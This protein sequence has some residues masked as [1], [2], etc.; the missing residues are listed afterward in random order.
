MN[1]LDLSAIALPFG[2]YRSG[3]PFGITLFAP[4]LADLR[5]LSLGKTIE[6]SQPQQSVAIKTA[7]IDSGYQRIAVC[8]AHMQ[9]LPLNGQLQTLGGRF[10]GR[11]RTAPNYRMYLL[12]AMPPERPGLVRDTS[13]G[14]ALDL[15]LWDLPKANWADFI[16]NIKSP[17]CIG[18]VELENGDW[19][20]GF[21]CENYP[22]S[23]A[24]EITKFG[25]WRAYLFANR[26]I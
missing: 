18:S 12:T 23:N 11:M 21:L 17:L 2:F 20:Y 6:S 9:G 3:L 25:G 24:T 14:Q 15:E 22:L 4:A 1:L 10:F 7:T 16:A 5:L 8:G 13:A 19:E 26:I